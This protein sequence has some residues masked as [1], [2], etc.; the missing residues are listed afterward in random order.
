MPNKYIKFVLQSV[1]KDADFQIN[2][3]E[4]SAEQSEIQLS[5]AIDLPMMLKM[6]LSSKLEESLDKIA[7]N[8]ATVLNQ[9]QID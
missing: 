8:F 1:L 2:I 7:E 5:L 9:P 4:L 6:V 3:N